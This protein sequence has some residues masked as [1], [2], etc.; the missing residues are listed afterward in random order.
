[1]RPER[2]APRDVPLGLVAQPLPVRLGRFP[3]QLGYRLLKRLDVAL[4][5]QQRRLPV[6]PFLFPPLTLE[7]QEFLHTLRDVA[8]GEHVVV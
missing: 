5:G 3:P 4:S 6:L 8:R 2:G 7:I 1:M